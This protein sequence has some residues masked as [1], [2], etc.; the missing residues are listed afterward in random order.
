MKEPLL[1]IPPR[2]GRK[3]V[4]TNAVFACPLIGTDKFV[5][6]CR[7]RGLQT[8]RERL[9]RLEQLGLFA[10]VFRV[11]TPKIQRSHFDI[12]LRPGNN[13]FSKRWAFD[14]TPVPGNHD[15]P[16]PSDRTR[17][18]YY[19]IFQIDH[20]QVVLTAMT[21]QLQLDSYLDSEQNPDGHHQPATQRWLTLAEQGATELRGHQFRRA[22]AL[23]C[24]H[25]S[26]RY[27]PQTETDMRTMQIRSGHSSDN[28]IAVHAQIWNWQQEARQWD[29][30]K[31]EKLYQ[32]T[33]ES[34]RHAY[35]SLAMTQAHCDP[36]ERWYQLTQFVS[37]HE[38]R[39]LKGDALR[40]ET[41]RAGAHMLRL[42]HKDLYGEELPHPNEV[43]GTIANHVP[44]LEVRRDVRR[45]LEFV[46]NRFAVNPQPRLS[47]IVE[48]KS[49]ET[50]I[51]LI[52]ER[53]YGAHPGVHGIE[54]I[55]L[56]GTGT[57][58]GKKGADR[59][60]AIVRLI[61]Y[62]HHHQTFAFL[63]L[64]NEGD[65]C[66]LRKRATD[67]ASI[68]GDRRYVT[69]PEYIQIWGTA[70]EFD[71]FSCTEIAA[72][73]TELASGFAKFSVNEVK[74]AKSS[75]NPGSA[76]KSLYENKTNYGL[77]K[78]KLAEILVDAL[79]SPAARR[80]IENRP[81]IRILNRVERLA[82]RNHL[83]TTQRSRTINQASWLLLRKS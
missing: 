53:Y 65:V 5:Q 74:N 22:V 34:L 81:I 73:L 42:L 16:D 66:R 9:L 31:T 58:T 19:S 2:A 36:I 45:H 54:I 79:M 46:S 72:A 52:F 35:R 71:N 76:L 38:R 12:P 83:P 27:F 23:L 25:I 50:A 75:P 4:Q 33:P 55:D 57:A 70:F 64:D 29:P 3:I 28:W 62:L 6:F 18:G 68:H 61:D 80:K 69:R 51:T 37:V 48:G 1:T 77:Q 13:W 20:L 15:V 10:P 78:V 41:L 11:R 14:T 63:I 32:L 17:E 82:A 8:D 56:K 7:A 21:L 47:L 40:A 43:R 67:A 39:K 44:E 24:Q 30:K 60:A 26:N 49:E 59:S